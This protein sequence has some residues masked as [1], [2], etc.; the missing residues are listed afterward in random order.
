M[1]GPDPD[2]HRHARRH[3]AG[4]GDTIFD[5]FTARLPLSISASGELRP[6]APVTLTISGEAQEAIDGGEVVF[7]L[8]TKAAMDYAGAGRTPFYP[9]GRTIPA[10]AS[11]RLSRMRKGDTW[12]RTVTVPGEAAGYYMAAV[13]ADANGPASALGPYLSDESYDQAWMLVSETGGRLTEVFE[14][15]VFAGGVVPMP[16]P[17]TTVAEFLS[18]PATQSA[19]G[20]SLYLKLKVGY[21]HGS[22]WRAA[23]GAK[24][25]GQ[26]VTKEGELQGDRL[27]RI[28]PEDGE[29]QFPCP[30]ERLYMVGYADLP[31]TRFIEVRVGFVKLWVG[32]RVHCVPHTYVSLN[33]RDH[34]YMP[35]R[36][37]SDVIPIINDHFGY[38]RSRVKWE[39]DFRENA[40][41]HYSTGCCLGLW[42][43][44]IVFSRAHYHRA[45]VAAHEYTHALHHKAMGGL[46]PA[47]NC[48]P[49][50][51]YDSSSYT[52]AFQEGLADYGSWVGAPD[53]FGY[54]LETI[55][56]S[57]CTYRDGGT[58]R[59]WWVVQGPK[60]KV[61]GHVAALFND[62]IDA[63]TGD[64]GTP[65]ETD[66]PADKT[67]YSAHY[68]MDVFATCQVRVRG[69][70]GGGTLWWKKRDDV[71]DFVWCL[72]NRVKAG[73]HRGVFPNIETPT[74]AREEAREPS[75]WNADSIRRTW[76]WNMY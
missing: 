7:M 71:S 63:G 12:R 58:C 72:E 6:D 36:N 18:S 67:Q 56:D 57:V 8:P 75:D 73:L 13:V 29:V 74:D 32:S 38:S 61:E 69:G 49:H 35:W 55:P 53:D 41:T 65:R 30:T 64:P 42:S 4:G 11:W 23:V 48:S 22:M 40:R 59:E 25:W 46:W 28:V 50:D 3:G 51:Y 44:K 14:D 9:L 31:E 62:L 10:T 54:F 1:R 66:E 5:P 21:Y 19:E 47:E 20:D 39:V 15:S 17:F 26:Y 33:G 76:L 34:D 24:V 52:C 70:K 43:D 2:R 27:Y 60:P 16:G 68:V 45:S 37:L